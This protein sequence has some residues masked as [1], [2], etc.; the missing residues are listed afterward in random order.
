MAYSWVCSAYNEDKETTRF[1]YREEILCINK[2]S[3]WTEKDNTNIHQWVE[4]EATQ[5]KK[6]KLWI[7]IGKTG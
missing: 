3:N 5:T 2:F 7:F 6:S 4:V 1:L